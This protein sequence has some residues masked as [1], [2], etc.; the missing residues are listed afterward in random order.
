LSMAAECGDKI[1]RITSAWSHMHANLMPSMVSICNCI[2]H[3]PW[4][5]LSEFCNVCSQSALVVIPA[6]ICCKN[7]NVPE[8]W[9]VFIISVE[10][11]I[12]WFCHQVLCF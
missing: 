3:I 7:Q 5:N 12:W 11:P 4:H 10:L 8:S 6:L 1:L 9:P 2:H